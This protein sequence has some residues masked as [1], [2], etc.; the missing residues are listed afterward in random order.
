MK[1]QILA[2]AMAAVLPMG[3]QAGV[4]IYGKI[5]T[6]I[7]FISP[8]AGGDYSDVTSRAS[9]IGFKGSEDLGNGL[10]LVWKAESTYDTSGSGGFGSG[11]NTYIGLAGGWGTFLYGRHDTPTKISTGKLD[12]FSDELG[13]YNAS[14]GIIDVRASDAIAYISPSMGGLTLAGAVVPDGDYDYD[15]FPPPGGDE[16]GDFAGAYYVAAMYGNVPFYLAGGYESLDD[17]SNGADATHWRV[18]AGFDIGAFHVGGIYQDADDFGYDSWLVNGSWTFGNN[19]VKAAYN[20]IDWN[21]GSDTDA[22]A[23]GFDHNFSKRSK[24]YAQYADSEHGLQDTNAIGEIGRASC[25]E[26]V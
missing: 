10:K 20:S 13:D 23:I 21:G 4:T 22:W 8:D 5:H 2:L 18:G 15:Q 6:S 12:V 9:R 17:I 19:A 25:R 24:V 16:G 26:R 11:R 1:K 7:D 3:A 14:A